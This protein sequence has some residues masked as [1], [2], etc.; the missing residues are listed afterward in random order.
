MKE[1]VVL[2]H[3]ILR[4]KSCM[5]DLANFLEARN[6]KTLNLDY[7]SSRLDISALSSLINYEVTNFSQT[8]TKIH[9]VGY[10]LGGLIIRA[11]LNHFRHNKLGRVVMLAPPNKG[12]EIADFLESFWLYKFLFGP[13]GQ[14]LVTNQLDFKKIFGNINYELGIIA[15]ESKF[16]FIANRIIGEKNDGRVSITNTMI[17]GMKEHVII[18][19]RHRV[20]ASQK[21]S[22]QLTLAFLQNGSFK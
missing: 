13:A 20:I 5:Q 14:Q 7:P 1:G 6:F 4:T 17:E 22:W 2:L 8:V 16:N 15:G 18:E 12:S 10:S 19:S 3:G 11:Y 21:K 9:F